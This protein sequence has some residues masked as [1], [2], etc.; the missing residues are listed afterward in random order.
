MDTVSIIPTFSFLTIGDLVD[1]ISHVSWAA[2]IYEVLKW[3]IVAVMIPVVMLRKE[4]PTAA[5]AW[6]AVVFLE[7][8]VGLALYLLVGESR[9]GRKRLDQRRSTKHVLSPAQRPDI[10]PRFVINPTEESAHGILVYLAEQVGGLPVVG[11]NQVRSMID[12]TEAIDAIVA[13][14]DSAEK[15]VH[16]LFYIYEADE[17]GRRV[18]DALIRAARRGVR[19][20][21]LADAVG[22]R[23]LFKRLAPE[24]RRE[25]VEVAQ[26][27]P[28]GL[29]RTLFARMDLRNHRKIVVVDGRIA[30]TGS[31]N[32][33]EPSYGHKRAGNWY[34]A[35][36]RIEGPAALQLQGIFVE[37]WFHESGHLL[38]E[39]YLYPDIEEMG[40]TAIQ[41]VA[42]GPDLPTGAFQDLIVEAIFRAESRVVITSPYFVPNE[43]MLMALRLAVLRG[44]RVDVVVP[45]TSDQRLV[46]AAGQFYCEYLMRY[47]GRVHLFD[48][49]LLHCKTLTIDNTMAMFGSAN[50]DVRSFML[51][52]EVNLLA[53]APDTVEGV[54]ELQQ[55]YIDQ[56][57]HAT[58]EDMPGRTFVGKLKMNFAKLFTPL[59]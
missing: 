27:L 33:V 13:D 10:D 8:F 1:A 55:Y 40:P 38:E 17:V 26:A 45:K 14:I 35:M 42:T 46:G 15:H 59:L 29:I 36:V 34:D 30:F 37:D 47:G 53:H 9:L 50:F 18:A 56:S 31:Q 16:L 32:I 19:C 41:V 43:S 24:L 23:N 49:G 44:V 25:G 58:F 52:F 39:E 11:G 2:L 3:G 12:T 57:I 5:I 54:R 51:N 4:K 6:L 7:P 28:V 21:L 22:S 20:R 48:K